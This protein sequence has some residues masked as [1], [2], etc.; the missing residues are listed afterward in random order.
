V[1]KVLNSAFF[2]FSRR[3][4]HLFRVF[5]IYSCAIVFE[6]RGITLRKP[7]PFFLKTFVRCCPL[8][9]YVRK[10]YPF[11]LAPQAQRRTYFAARNETP[12]SF[13]RCDERRG[14]RALDLRDLFE[15]RSIKNFRKRL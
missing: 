12:K 7:S 3:E 1:E 4:L 10:P 6:C 5:A 13:A 11:F 2:A 8:G 15:K 9:C 14:L